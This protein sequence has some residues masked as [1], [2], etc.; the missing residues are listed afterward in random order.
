MEST[1]IGLSPA[2]ILFV[3]LSLLTT[4]FSIPPFYWH[5]KHRNLAASALIFWII[6]V[7][8]FYFI[9]AL[10]WPDDNLDNWWYGS[11]FCDLEV[12]LQV[13]AGQG[14]PAS[15]ICI[16]RNLARVLDTSRTVLQPTS[17]Q[18]RRRIIVDCLLCFGAPV[19]AMLAH[20][21]IQ[22]ARYYIFAIA[23]CL[24]SYDNSWPSIVLIHIWSPIG[25]VI[26]VYYSSKSSTNAYLVAEML[27]S[28]SCHSL[29]HAQVSQGLRCHP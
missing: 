8:C 2:G 7:N 18:R 21:I 9:N 12:K 27:T 19:Y 29:P 25:A 10:I 24:P 17:A 1:D 4:L 22:D 5:I 23:G 11:G 13:A 3:V 28:P 20:L 26:A 16:M 14:I 6:I 15:L